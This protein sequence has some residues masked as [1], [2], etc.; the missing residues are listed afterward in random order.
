MRKIKLFFE[1]Y[2]WSIV[3]SCLIISIILTYLASLFRDESIFNLLGLF[4]SFVSLTSLFVTC[5]AVVDINQ[6]KEQIKLE[7]SFNNI[8]SNCIEKDQQNFYI[9]YKNV[10]LKKSE[11]LLKDLNILIKDDAE[12]GKS[13]EFKSRLVDYSRDCFILINDFKYV[14]T[15]IYNFSN[16]KKDNNV[17]NNE[18]IKRT[19]GN[20]CEK[21]IEELLCNLKKLYSKDKNK[22]DYDLLFNTIKEYNNFCEIIY[23]EIDIRIKKFN[24]YSNQVL[25]SNMD[26]DSESNSMSNLESI[27]NMIDN[28]KE[29]EFYGK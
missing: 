28:K 26:S 15:W 11:Q 2:N 7:E 22:I 23:D 5:K 12:T 8:L 3:I 13:N 4:L 25:S 19:R 16:Y 18:E 17:K 21:D 20:Y 27:G 9:N 1:N 29:A 14:K 24:N 6:V 10:Y